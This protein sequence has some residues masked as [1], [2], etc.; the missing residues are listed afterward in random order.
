MNR[1]SL[2]VALTLLVFAGATFVVL[3]CS[4]QPTQNPEHPAGDAASLVTGVDHIPLTVSDLL[5][6]ADYR[7]YQ[8]KHAGRNRVIA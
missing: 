8:A 7:L 3:G 5:R 6:E 1:N 4:I 2:S